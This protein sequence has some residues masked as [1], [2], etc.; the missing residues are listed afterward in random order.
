MAHR[1]TSRPVDLGETRRRFLFAREQVAAH[2]PADRHRVKR[3][4][5]PPAGR[6]D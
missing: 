1:R 5:C 2:V 3:V 6:R 4:D